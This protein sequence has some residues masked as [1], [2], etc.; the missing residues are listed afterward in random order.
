MDPLQVSITERILITLYGREKPITHLSPAQ[1]LDSQN[2]EN[3]GG[4]FT[5]LSFK[6]VC[7][8]GI[9]NW[10]D[11]QSQFRNVNFGYEIIKIRYQNMKCIFG[12]RKKF[13]PNCCASQGVA[14]SRNDGEG[15]Y[16]HPG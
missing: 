15:H 12:G 4:G 2:H 3:G 14:N 11:M 6:V 8:T 9:D 16:L 7:Y 10:N 1:I 13:V 5:L